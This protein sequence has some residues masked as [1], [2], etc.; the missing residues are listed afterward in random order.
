VGVTRK[1]AVSL[2]AAPGRRRATIEIA[3]RFEKEG[4]AGIYCPSFG[5]GLA[6]CEALAF[7][8]KEIRFG[9][10]IA[11]IYSRHP[12]DYAA[13]A[14]F[15]HEASGGRAE[16][17]D[18]GVGREC[19]GCEPGNSGRAGEQESA[20]NRVTDEFEITVVPMKSQLDVDAEIHTHSQ[21]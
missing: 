17:R 8:T 11:N 18:A 4:F 9:T 14:A 10:S 13:T 1:P 15:I 12:H 16:A 21:E 3:Q 6:L 2:A 20:A 5:D 7:E 19:D